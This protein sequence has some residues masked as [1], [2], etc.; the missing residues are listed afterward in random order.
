MD[1]CK[2]I[3]KQQGQVEK[4]NGENKKIDYGYRG[5]EEKEEETMDASKM[6]FGIG[7]SHV[8]GRNIQSFWCH[9]NR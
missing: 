2:G 9:T 7:W 1:V 6:C 4:Y 8:N 3:I 5:L